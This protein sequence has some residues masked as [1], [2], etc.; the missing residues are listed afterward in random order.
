MQRRLHGL[1]RHVWLQ[2][3]RF[4]ERYFALAVLQITDVFFAVLDVVSGLVMLFV[5]VD[6]SVHFVVAVVLLLHVVVDRVLEHVLRRLE[7]H[8]VVVF[9]IV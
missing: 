8:V 9:V 3:D 2:L 7:R 4:V 1:V 6:K 5:S